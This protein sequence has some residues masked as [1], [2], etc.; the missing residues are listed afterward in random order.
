MSPAPR[1]P[2][3]TQANGA[4]ARA[5][6]STG[7]PAPPPA[8]KGNLQVDLP[9]G[10]RLTLKNA[11]E[12]TLWE[13]SARRYITDYGISKTNDLVLLGAILSQNIA[14]YRAQ[15][16]L[17]DPKKANAAVTLIGKTSEQIR[18]LEK[19]LGIDKKTREQGGQHTVAD[20]VTRLKRAGNAKGVRIAER[21]KAFE[22]FN[23]ELRWKLRLLENGDD[24][25]R[26][27]HNLSPESICAWARNELAKLE[28]A[29]KQWAMQKGKIF[30]GRL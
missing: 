11:D 1:K 19:A 2:P 17:G 28:E 25:D 13:E 24:E 26:A 9:A 30:V 16:D 27:Y 8:G 29:D 6:K 18:E 7:A 12:V 22:A 14:M 15:L 23:M 5:T 4:P 20:Y 10:G 3:T 21:V